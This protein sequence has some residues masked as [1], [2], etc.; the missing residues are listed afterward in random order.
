MN[1][2]I[3]PS[4]RKNEYVEIRD[5]DTA[6]K[7]NAKVYHDRRRRVKKSPVKIGDRVLMKN[8][9]TDRLNPDVGTVIQVRDNTVTAAFCDGRFF[10]G[11][12]SHFKRSA[13]SGLPVIL[14]KNHQLKKN[15]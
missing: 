13:Q 8:Q 15:Q 9:R 5:R 12:K 14:K 10:N 2:K 4:I 3:F 7:R 1:L 11:N 6:Y